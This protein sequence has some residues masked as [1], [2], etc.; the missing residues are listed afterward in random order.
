MWRLLRS[1]LP[2]TVE[3]FIFQLTHEYG[4][5]ALPFTELSQT[6]PAQLDSNSVR[7]NVCLIPVRMSCPFAF[8]SFW[9]LVGSLS[10]LFTAHLSYPTLLALVILFQFNLICF[11]IFPG[12]SKLLRR[13]AG[14]STP[15][16]R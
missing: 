15:V 12:Q 7:L 16:H 2:F 4:L 6:T 11:Q 5:A 13:S 14:G 9:L 10:L 3:T 8:C 1:T